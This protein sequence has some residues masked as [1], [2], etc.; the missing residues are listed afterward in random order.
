MADQDDLP[1]AKSDALDAERWRKLVKCKLFDETTMTN[2]ID[3]A[4]AKSKEGKK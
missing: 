4:I 1:Q 2:E 3:A